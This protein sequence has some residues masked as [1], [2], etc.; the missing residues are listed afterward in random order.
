MERIGRIGLQIR[1]TAR[2][3][4]VV[5][6]TYLTETLLGL[7]IATRHLY[8]N[9]KLPYIQIMAVVKPTFHRHPITNRLLRA[10]NSRTE[11]DFKSLALVLFKNNKELYCACKECI[12][13]FV[14][15]KNY[16][17]IDSI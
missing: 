2:L 8:V 10:T 9:K 16:A 12:K 4:T 13:C 7:L 17:D 15:C 14:K 11:D 1:S 6:H 5:V 3:Y